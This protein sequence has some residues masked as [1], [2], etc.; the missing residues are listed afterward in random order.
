M[1]NVI[2][3][4]ANCVNEKASGDYAIAGQLAVSFIEA[5]SQPEYQDSGVEVV[6][7]TTKDR[8]DSFTRLYGKASGDK[9][10][11]DGRQVTLLA[12][13]DLAK[14]PFEII[15]YIPA[16]HCRAMPKEVLNEILTAE[17]KV[18]F[19]FGPHQPDY[20]SNYF[21]SEMLIQ[22]MHEEFGPALNYNVI[23]VDSLGFVNDSKRLGLSAIKSAA[24]LAPLTTSETAELA[25]V[26]GKKYGV[27]YFNANDPLVGALCDEFMRLGGNGD[28][29]LVGDYAESLKRLARNV[30]YPVEF[31]L[32]DGTKGSTVRAGDQIA[33][34]QRKQL[35]NQVLRHAMARSQLLVGATGVNFLQEALIDGKI[36]YYQAVSNNQGFIDSYLASLKGL[37]MADSNTP[38][39]LKQEVLQLAAILMAEKPLS[40]VAHAKAKSGLGNDALVTK[41][42]A[43]NT[44]LMKGAQKPIAPQLL[45]FLMAPVDEKVRDRQLA[46]ALQKLRK[47]EEKES[48]TFEQGLRRAAAWGK[49]IELRVILSCRQQKG[50]NVNGS[51]ANVGMTPLHF[52]VQNKQQA[53]INALLKHGADPMATD[54]KGRTALSIAIADESLPCLRL[55]M[56]AGG[57]L[58]QAEQAQF[59]RCSPA[60]KA[61]AATLCSPAVVVL[62]D[63]QNERLAT[64]ATVTPKAAST[65]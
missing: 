52:A 32:T 12:A 21:V 62:D 61:Q 28:Y 14:K 48:P 6:L 56:A 33:F 43:M 23:T 27:A 36:P 65:R 63:E 41:L 7:T 58:S 29:L 35:S 46:M 31:E 10:S 15:G 22:R 49:L 26:S 39:S 9:I 1:K 57:Q 55:L 44:S 17:T 30:D 34:T 51:V 40:A 47:P 18:S 54:A 5:L 59:G 24:E 19:V 37:M 13:E 20:K 16:N 60:F 38:I 45:P 4:S 3:I 25:S 11:I 42:S 53:V 50:I 64:A 2:V 8:M